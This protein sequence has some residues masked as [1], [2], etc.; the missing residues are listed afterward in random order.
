MNPYANEN[1]IL[2]A[3]IGILVGDNTATGNAVECIQSYVADRIFRSNYVNTQTFP[4]ITVFYEDAVQSLTLPSREGFLVITPW[5]SFTDAF[6]LTK[7][8]NITE[9]IQNLITAASLNLAVNGK[10]LRCRLVQLISAV[11]T[12]DA[13]TECYANVIRF[14]LIIDDQALPT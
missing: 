4:Q 10:N 14:R 7:L 3:S 5:V 13:L 1:L 9:R 8:A 6:P 2:E 12:S 11:K